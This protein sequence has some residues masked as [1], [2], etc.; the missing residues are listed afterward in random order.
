MPWVV[1]GPGQAGGQRLGVDAHFLQ[2][3]VTLEAAGQA[4][5][6]PATGVR[7][8]AGA[9]RRGVG[10]LFAR[11][12]VDVLP[13]RLVEVVPEQSGGEDEVQLESRV[14]EQLPA[15]L[16][17]AGEPV[18]RGEVPDRRQ[19]PGAQRLRIDAGP[20]AVV[21]PVRQQDGVAENDGEAEVLVRVVAACV[22]PLLF[23]PVRVVQQD[24]VVDRRHLVRGAAA[25][26][27]PL[28]T[29]SL[30]AESQRDGGQSGGGADELDEATPVDLNRREVWH[31][32]RLSDAL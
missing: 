10:G 26:R 2:L 20:V 5:G 14:E 21:G 24:A 12:G 6:C 30:A 4:E 22:V 9:Q 11:D 16:G 15:P 19:R 23:G 3:G 25:A 32:R 13:G 8:V 29:G 17:A 28:G 31:C 18:G 27:R 7:I 1:R